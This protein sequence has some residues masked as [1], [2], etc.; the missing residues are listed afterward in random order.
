[1]RIMFAY[2]A[3]PIAL[4]KLIH[5]PTSS[6]GKKNVAVAAITMPIAIITSAICHQSIFK[7]LDFI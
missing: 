7:F 2:Y 4:K 5:A 1:L 3:A 6:P